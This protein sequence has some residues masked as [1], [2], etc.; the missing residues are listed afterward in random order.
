MDTAIAEDISRITSAYTY[1]P[2]GMIAKMEWRISRQ[3]LLR[4]AK[5]L[6]M[7]IMEWHIRNGTVTLYGRPVTPTDTDEILLVL[8]VTPAST[9]SG[10]SSH[11]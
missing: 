4:M 1:V 8:V 6:G 7:P 3:K 5:V 9:E 2:P 10:G 11:S